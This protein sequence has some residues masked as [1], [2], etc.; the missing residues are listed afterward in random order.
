MSSDEVKRK[1]AKQRR[2]KAFIAHC[3]M[4]AAMSDMAYSTLD[5]CGNVS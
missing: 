5:G 3:E 4:R 2:F 1:Q